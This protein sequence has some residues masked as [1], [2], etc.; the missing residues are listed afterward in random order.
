MDY[1]QLKPANGL[2]YLNLHLRRLLESVR[3]I[4]LSTKV[5]GNSTMKNEVLELKWRRYQSF[6]NLSEAKHKGIRME[7][8]LSKVTRVIQDPITNLYWVEI[9][10][11]KHSHY[12]NHT[13]D[14]K[15]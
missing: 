10:Y 8:L 11:G 13:L 14:V 5:K 2:E 1:T 12:I 15:Q 3:L 4:T 7:I 9:A 6:V